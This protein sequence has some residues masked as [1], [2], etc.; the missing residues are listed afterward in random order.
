MNSAF[1]AM[2]RLV[3]SRMSARI[4]KQDTRWLLVFDTTD[5]PNVADETEH[6]RF[7]AVAPA[8]GAADRG[9]S[10]RVV[11]RTELSREIRRP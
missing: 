10:R 4:S 7:T 1:S 11:L 3:D 5:D 9:F 6:E 2:E 8:L